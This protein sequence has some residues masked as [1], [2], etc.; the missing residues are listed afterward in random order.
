MLQQ[1]KQHVVVRRHVVHVL[2]VVQAIATAD[3]IVTEPDDI[4]KMEDEVHRL[5]KERI[6]QSEA[7]SHRNSTELPGVFQWF[8]DHD[9]ESS[10]NQSNLTFGT[11]VWCQNATYVSFSLNPKPSTLAALTT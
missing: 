4:V 6:V 11:W 2:A 3:R 1:Q 8:E 7:A 9:E 10:A 5:H